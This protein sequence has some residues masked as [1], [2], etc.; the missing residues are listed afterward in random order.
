MMKKLI[1]PLF[2][3]ATMFACKSPE[4]KTETAANPE[5]TETGS[6]VSMDEKSAIFKRVMEAAM[7]ND[8]SVYREAFAD[9][10]IVL[11]GFAENVDSLNKLKATPEGINALIKGDSYLH[12]LYDDIAM[13][14]EKGQIKTFTF[15]DGRIVSGYWGIWSA[16]GKFSKKVSR[17]PLHMIGWWKGDKVVQIY[18]LF[19]PASLKEEIALSQKK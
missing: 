7:K 6:F 17:V 8:T 16:K 19:D 10:L 5:D 13:T 18:R 2:L 4:S 14:T 9:S 1:L 11:D 12:S 15:T 3:L